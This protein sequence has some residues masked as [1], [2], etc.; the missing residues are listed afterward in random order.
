[1]FKLPVLIVVVHF[2]KQSFFLSLQRVLEYC[3]ESGDGQNDEL[4]SSNITQPQVV[5][6]PQNRDAQQEIREGKS[7]STQIAK[8][9]PALETL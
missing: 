4:C 6:S 9:T 8:H 7:P 1:M 3:K 2:R 5:G